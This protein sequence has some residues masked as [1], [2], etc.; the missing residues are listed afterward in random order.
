MLIHKL[1]DFEFTEIP[2]RPNTQDERVG[3]FRHTIALRFET[4]KPRADG[5]WASIR[6]AGLPLL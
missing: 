6:L 1:P 5:A 3:G 4:R 2:Q